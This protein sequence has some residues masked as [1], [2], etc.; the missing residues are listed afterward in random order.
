[1]RNKYEKIDVKQ[2][3]LDLNKFQDYPDF[4]LDLSDPSLEIEKTELNRKYDEIICL[5]VLEHV[6][7]PFI[8]LD[9]L[10][11]L[12][13]NGVIYGYVPFYIFITHPKI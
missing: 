1:M 2:K 12:K 6:Y 10:K 5:A 9:N 13:N 11:M 3:Y 8:A 7:N 4:Q